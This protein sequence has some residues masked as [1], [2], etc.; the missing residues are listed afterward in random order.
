MVN[1]TE[2]TRLLEKLRSLPIGWNY[3]TGGPLAGGAFVIAA[4]TL[5]YLDSMSANRL[6]VLPSSDAGATLL[7]RYGDSLAEI[8]VHKDGLIDLFL[9]ADVDVEFEGLDFGGLVSALEGAGWK[10]PK[11][12]GSQTHLFTVMSTSGSLAK[13]SQKMGR[14]HQWSPRNARSQQPVHFVRIS[15]NTTAELEESRP[16]SYAS[17]QKILETAQG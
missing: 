3:G 6:D 5:Q 4:L 12:F 11:S 16:F 15:K 1:L 7:A 13:H 10:S 9:E 2:A 8:I 14:V 17:P